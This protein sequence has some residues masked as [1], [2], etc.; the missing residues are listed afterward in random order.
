[1]DT[2]RVNGALFAA[3]MADNLL[4]DD[5]ASSHPDFMRENIKRGEMQEPFSLLRWL[6]TCSLISEYRLVNYDSDT[7]YHQVVGLISLDIKLVQS[8][9]DAI[10]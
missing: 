8:D 5:H 6:W 1:M 2:Y 3:G 10:S 9:C 7:E 4:T